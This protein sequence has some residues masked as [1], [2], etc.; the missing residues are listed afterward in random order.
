MSEAFL[1][2]VPYAVDVN[3]LKETYPVPK[4][5][6]GLLISHDEL[7]KVVNAKAQSGRYYG[8]VNSWI[9][10]IKNSNGIIIEWEPS[11]GVRVL[12]PAEVLESTEKRVSRKIGQT[13]RAIKGFAWVD[14]NR[15]DDVGQRRLDHQVQVASK[16]KTVLAA[17]KKESAIDI[18]PVQS[19]PKP[20]LIREG[21]A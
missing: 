3:K 12:N 1:G 20:K 13:G 8:V 19:L 2:G 16:L 21:V 7:E 15:L 9:S 18:A 14:R 6:E 4:L 11:K 17:H 10:Q 5:I